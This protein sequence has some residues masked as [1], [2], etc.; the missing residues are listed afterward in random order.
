MPLDPI[1]HPLTA[2]QPSRGPAYF[3]SVAFATCLA[4]LAF[5]G[6]STGDARDAQLAEQR[7]ATVEEAQVA[8]RQASFIANEFFD[9][10]PPPAVTA[11]PRAV[12]QSIALTTGVNSDGAPSGVY[13]SVPSNA[14]R[15]YVAA[16]VRY[17]QPGETVVASWHTIAA[18]P[19]DIVVI[20]NSEAT[21][22][23]TE[24]WISLP[25][26]LNGNVTPG[27]YAV[28]LYIEGEL[29]NSLAFEITSAGSAPRQIG[30]T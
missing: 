7:D 15:V 20:Y 18:K 19:A 9:G 11:T 21:V 24:E 13:G 30:N 2:T 5:V 6:C 14:G 26:D 1:D 3:L 12:L 22:D 17:L 23:G 10:T 8:A 25:A 27:K 16:R 28:S 29:L 4:L